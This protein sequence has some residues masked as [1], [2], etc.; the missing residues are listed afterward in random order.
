MPKKTP[1]GFEAFR[2]DTCDGWSLVAVKAP[3]DQVASVLESR[4]ETLEYER[5]VVPKP[6]EGYPELK[7]ENDKR[8]AYLVQLKTSEWTVLLRT[9]AWIELPDFDAV[10]TLAAE[11]SQ[12]LGAAAVASLSTDDGAMYQVFEGGV[13]TQQDTT[14]GGI[15]TFCRFFDDHGIQVPRCFISFDGSKSRLY[16]TDKS[17]DD[18]ARADRL[19]LQV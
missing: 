14:D 7:P 8:R 19:V 1:S 18:L 10:K 2:K 3:I 16:L 9:I 12:Q 6:L 13:L 5:G 17:P 4:P 15:K 11:L